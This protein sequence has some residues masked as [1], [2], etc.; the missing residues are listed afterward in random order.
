MKNI[1]YKGLG[2]VVYE[3][4]EGT[5]VKRYEKYLFLIS[6]DS[7]RKFNVAVSKKNP[8]EIKNLSY[9]FPSMVKIQ[10]AK[11]K[12]YELINKCLKKW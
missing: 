5:P 2:K 7:N 4:V 12:Y 1:N 9:I 11:Q 3:E 6:D 8:I 10:K